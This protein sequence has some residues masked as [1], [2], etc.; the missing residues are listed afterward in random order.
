VAERFGTRILKR[1][2][3]KVHPYLMH[4]HGIGLASGK[5]AYREID[6]RP[7]LVSRFAMSTEKR[8]R[9]LFETCEKPRIPWIKSSIFSTF[10]TILSIQCAQDESSESFTGFARIWVN[11][12]MELRGVRKS[13]STDWE[14]QLNS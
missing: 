10:P 7:F 8:W 5:I 13:W 4:Q 9:S 12:A 14:L 3:D 11:P 2:A 6:D 1:I